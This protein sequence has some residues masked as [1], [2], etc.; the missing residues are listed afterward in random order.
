MGSAVPGLGARGV[1][2]KKSTV[3]MDATVLKAEKND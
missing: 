1:S 2:D 3:A